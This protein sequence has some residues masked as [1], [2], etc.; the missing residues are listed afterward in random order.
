MNRRLIILGA[1]LVVVASTSTATAQEGRLS[2]TIRDNAGVLPGAVVV[3]TP[4]GPSR[5][6]RVVADDRGV[7]AVP[8][9][10]AGPI[11]LVVS[12]PGFA[13]VTER[14]TFPPGTAVHPV[15]IVMTVLR[16]SDQ[17]TVTTA[18]RREQVLLD[19]ADPTVVIEAAAIA[20]TGSRTAKDLLLE[21][22]GAG[23]QV[24]AG[25][26]Q[27]HISINGIPNRGVLVLVDGRRYLGKDA[28]GNFNLEDLT[29]QG[30][31]RV[32][33]VKGAGSA[34]YGSDAIGGV[35]NFVTKRPV[36]QGFTAS[37]EFG[38]GSYADWRLNQAVAWRG[39]RGGVRAGGG[40]RTY[41]GS[42]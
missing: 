26:G 30:I 15:E 31:E 8:G 25:G 22:A 12:F 23:V 13:D 27:G 7:A 5:A 20:D 42:T 1:F 6:V 3:A 24:Q 28:N 37:T 14:L 2:V 17:T 21:Q 19:V 35:V 16:L 10:P 34:L 36:A 38:G 40:Y 41:D 39:P 32:E 9:L 18:N 29:L 11:D 4:T 33:I